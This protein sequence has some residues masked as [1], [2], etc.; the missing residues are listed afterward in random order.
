MSGLSYGRVIL[1]G[2]CW[3]ALGYAPFLSAFSMTSHQAVLFSGVDPLP[4]STNSTA[5]S[6]QS[7]SGATTARAYTL[8]TANAF[9]V[10]TCSYAETKAYSTG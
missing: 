1:M 4:P 10:I 6:S 3:G 7:S 9:A 8:T 5:T 2:L